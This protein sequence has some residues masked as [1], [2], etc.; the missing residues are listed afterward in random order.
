[1]IAASGMLEL[2]IIRLKHQL[3]VLEQQQSMSQPYPTHQAKLIQLH[4]NLQSKLQD[5]VERQQVTDRSI[6]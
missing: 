1:M 2:K 3:N 6:N 4:N 5:L